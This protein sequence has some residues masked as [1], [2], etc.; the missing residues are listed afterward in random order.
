MRILAALSL[1]PLAARAEPPP[2]QLAYE[3]YVAGFRV[4]TL[5]TLASVSAD[6]YRVEI[7]YRTAGVLASFISGDLHSTVQGQFRDLM[8]Q[9]QRFMSWGLWLGKARQT[10][11]DY[12]KGDPVVRTL[13]PLVDEAREPVP[14]E[15]TPGT[16][17]SLSAVAMLVHRVT[18]SGRCEGK[19]RVFDGRR[20]SEI[21]ARTGGIEVLKREHG[22]RFA[23]PALRCD[24][25]GQQLAGFLMDG[26]QERMH[27]PQEGA[28]WMA[29]PAP[30]WPVMPV[31]M[32]FQVR[33]F[34]LGT[35]YL[36]EVVGQP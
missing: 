27:R 31:R 12:P 35:M 32:R 5:Q 10:L 29:V 24:F 8:A 33:F 20:L 1:L 21:V 4:F 25:V 18:A 6:A 26:D 23:G 19:A 36:S 11:I 15:T 7:G 3:G 28:A 22:S 16:V 17:D 30:G 34:G 13:V 2:V 14:P 9:P